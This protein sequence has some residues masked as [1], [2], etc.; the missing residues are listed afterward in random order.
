MHVL[1]I[2]AGINPPTG[3]W[4][5]HDNFLVGDSE[6]GDIVINHGS[7]FDKSDTGFFSLEFERTS[8]ESLSASVALRAIGFDS[9]SRHRYYGMIPK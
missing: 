8:E 4:I 3:K 2:L 6:Y 7:E 1:K 9:F 5:A